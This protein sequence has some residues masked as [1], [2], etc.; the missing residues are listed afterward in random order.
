MLRFNINNKH[1]Y[2]MKK[3]IFKTFTLIFLISINYAVFAQEDAKFG[4]VR[5]DD[6]NNPL[7]EKYPDAEAIKLYDEGLIYF[8]VY[9]EDFKTIFEHTVRIK[10]LSQAGLDWANVSIPYFAFRNYEEIGMI[11][12]YTFN[13]DGNKVNKEKLRNRD[14]FEE[15]VDGRWHAK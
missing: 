14:I 9:K 3:F 6:F 13:L 8:D 1:H 2:I 5:K 12:G 4:K 7:I 10:I 15:D 11:K